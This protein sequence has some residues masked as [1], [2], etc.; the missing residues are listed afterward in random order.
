MAFRVH[1][2]EKD[3]DYFNPSV[4]NSVVNHVMLDR[5]SSV[6]LPDRIAIDP[7]PGVI[8]QD[9]NA[10]IELVEVGIGLL[11]SP[12]LERMVPDTDQIFFGECLL[13]DLKH[14]ARLILP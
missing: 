14:W 3:P 7:E 1:F 13:V 9:G 6:A 11:N 12:L 2:F 5:E 10:F 4:G 8:G